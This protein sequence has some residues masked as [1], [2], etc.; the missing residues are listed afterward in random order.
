MSCLTLFR[1]NLSSALR[2]LL[3]AV[4]VLF[5]IYCLQ[6]L[7][8]LH[9]CLP[10]CNEFDRMLMELDLHVIDLLMYCIIYNIGQC[11]RKRLRRMHR[12]HVDY[13]VDKWD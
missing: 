7:L 11:N 6:I 2:R 9:I 4:R 1:V 10:T 13:D 8:L 3:Y 12:C 5:Q